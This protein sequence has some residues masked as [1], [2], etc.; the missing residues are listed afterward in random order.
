MISASPG[1]SVSTTEMHKGTRKAGT[2]GDRLSVEVPFSFCKFPMAV[3]KEL[4][5]D[6]Q[7]P[8]T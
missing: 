8:G 3:V 1:S 2:G 5:V 4:R 6:I 7:L